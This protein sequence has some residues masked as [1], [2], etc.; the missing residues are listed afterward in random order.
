MQWYISL[1]DGKIIHS[2]LDVPTCKDF[3]EIMQ[4]FSGLRKGAIGQHLK[5]LRSTE[6]EKQGKQVKQMIRHLV[7]AGLVKLEEIEKAFQN[8]PVK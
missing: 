4:R 3:V 2:G 6:V 1:L 8:L 7:V 5:K